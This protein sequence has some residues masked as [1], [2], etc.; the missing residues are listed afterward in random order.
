M[1]QSLQ[2]SALWA[3]PDRGLGPGP[4]PDLWAPSA[5]GWGCPGMLLYKG[6]SSCFLP[7]PLHFILSVSLSQA[8]V[9]LSHKHVRSELIQVG[10]PHPR[11]STWS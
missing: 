11:G 2:M 8:S 4:L 3:S 1:A 6:T 7:L 9:N 10:L 5:S